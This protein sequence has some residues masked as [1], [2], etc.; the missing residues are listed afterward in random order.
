V[1]VWHSL[2]VFASR[3]CPV[4]ASNI[5]DFD[6]KKRFILKY[7]F[8]KMFYIEQDATSN[9]WAGNY[10]LSCDEMTVC[11]SWSVL[12]SAA[13]R[14][15]WIDMIS[16]ANPNTLPHTH[17]AI[18]ITRRW[19]TYWSTNIRGEY[20]HTDR[21]KHNWLNLFYL[22]YNRKTTRSVGEHHSNNDPNNPNIKYTTTNQYLYNG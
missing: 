10:Q 6:Q 17:W 4:F 19:S 9:E 1:Y 2:A 11:Q 21:L 18:N 22:Q 12:V 8:S 20:I 14:F 5:N 15:A 16:Q 13:A 7:V 3:I